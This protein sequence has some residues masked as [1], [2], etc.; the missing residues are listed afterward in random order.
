MERLTRRWGN[1]LAINLDAGGTISPGS[2][3][4]GVVARAAQIAEV[5]VRV[6]V[7]L[8][9][10]IRLSKS[11]DPTDVTDIQLFPEDYSTVVF[12]GP[13]SLPGPNN[14]AFWRFSITVPTFTSSDTQPTNQTLGPISPAAAPGP[15]ASSSPSPPPPYAPV[16]GHSHPLPCSFT[17]KANKRRVRI[18]YFLIAAIMNDMTNQ[19]ADNGRAVAREPLS[20]PP[21]PPPPPPT[22]PAPRPTFQNF[23]SNHRVRTY[24][25]AE[26]RP[27]MWDRITDRARL[28]NSRNTPQCTFNVIVRVPKHI[29][30][31]TPQPGGGNQAQAQQ[32][33]AAGGQTIPLT[34]SISPVPP[35][36]G[37][38][39]GTSDPPLISAANRSFILKSAT[40]KLSS[41]TEITLPDQPPERI[42]QSLGGISVTSSSSSDTNNSSA[43]A[44]QVL[45][46]PSGIANPG[47]DLGQTVGLRLERGAGMYSTR[48]ETGGGG[49]VRNVGPVVGGVYP[50]FGA[51]S[52]VKHTHLLEWEVRVEVAGERVEAKGGFGVV[53]TT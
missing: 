10:R 4:T 36:P 2:V 40:I 23:N 24:R 35:P 31:N 30:I 17:M 43:G 8:Y 7:T 42:T 37:H 19:I 32:G 22:T 50:D 13:L 16:A 38:I 14:P 41:V 28:M 44:G 47:L 53:V 18:E 51:V 34:I 27:N 33:Q 39:P 21:S 52:V 46:I 48:A 25:L 6:K 11:K 29:K 15:V 20:L 5:A 49:G 3:I 12:S 1:E 26:I 45:Q 9:G